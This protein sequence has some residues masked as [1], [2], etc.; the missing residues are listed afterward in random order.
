MGTFYEE[1]QEVAAELIT[2]FGAAGELEKSGSVVPDTDRAWEFS[3]EASPVTE[4]V[5]VAAVP[6]TEKAD[7]DLLENIEVFKEARWLLISSK[8]LVNIVEPNDQ[9]T[10][11]S[12][13][14]KVIS[15]T[16][17]QPADIVVMYSC[18]G[19]I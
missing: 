13:K 10:A 7:Q 12:K 6:V 2:E 17:I 9:V 18:I 15:V 3:A 19:I 14:W 16:A 5:V 11:V 4:A 1:M 8:D